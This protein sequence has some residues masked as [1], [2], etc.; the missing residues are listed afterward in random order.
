MSHDSPAVERGNQDE[1][2]VEGSLLLLLEPLDEVS[3]SQVTLLS[4]IDTRR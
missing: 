4:Y 3:R 1:E 2:I